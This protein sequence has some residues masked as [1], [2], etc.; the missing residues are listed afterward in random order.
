MMQHN[1]G[2]S[3]SIAS[4]FIFISLIG[5]I[6]TGC[7]N[8]ENANK[9][10]STES[11]SSTKIDTPSQDVRVENSQQVE[12]KGNN[13]VRLNSKTSTTTSDGVVTRS[14]S[15]EKNTEVDRT[16]KSSTKIVDGRYWVGA[17]DQGLEVDGDRYRYD[18]E[19]GEQPWQSI[20]NLKSVKYGVVFD[21]KT[22]WCLSTLAPNPATGCSANGWSR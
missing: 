13:N 6:V 19:G 12:I 15:I 17:T 11:R 21:G 4:L 22:Y 16:D 18:T 5:T 9:Q 14:E 3:H 7:T 20:S 1:H 2:F 8:V 10:R